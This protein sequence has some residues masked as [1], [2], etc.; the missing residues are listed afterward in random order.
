MIK[1][2]RSYKLHEI[3]KY[4]ILRHNYLTPMLYKVRIRVAEWF[5]ILLKLIKK[6]FGLI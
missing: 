4:D 2:N 1:S 3:N 6:Q 5:Y